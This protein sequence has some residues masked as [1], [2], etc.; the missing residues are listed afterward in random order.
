MSLAENY[1]FNKSASIAFYWSNAEWAKPKPLYENP[2]SAY[3]ASGNPYTKQKEQTRKAKNL[4]CLLF[5]LLVIFLLTQ[6]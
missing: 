4:E 3:F 5:F 6:K 1:C 2:Q